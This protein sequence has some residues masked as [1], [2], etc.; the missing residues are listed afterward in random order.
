MKYT[1]QQ[2][3]NELNLSVSTVSRV[4]AGKQN[5][6]GQ[7]KEQ[8]LNY[9]REHE[10]S[11]PP[12]AGSCDGSGQIVAVIIP[13]LTED[14]FA[15]VIRGIEEILWQEKSSMM[16]CET[17]EDSTKEEQYIEVLRRKKIT[18]I[19]LATVSKDQERIRSYLRDDANIVF[20]DNLPNLTT[21]YNSV[22]TDNVRAS[23]MAV[24]HLV[25]QGHEKIGIIAGKQQETTGFER[26]VGYRRALD[27]RGI[28]QDESLVAIGNFKEESGYQCM[29]E[30]LDKNPG[31][32]A[33]Y[34]SSSKMTYGA[35]KAIFSR[36]LS[37]PQDIALVGF[38]VHDP[39]GLV[40][41]GITTILQNEANIGKL[42]VELLHKKE[43]QELAGSQALYQRILLEPRLVIRESC[44]YGNPKAQVSG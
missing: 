31:M 14:Y 12:A 2:I 24:D 21:N 28:G 33:V 19:I 13:D 1:L 37:I 17:M 39:T 15:H 26:L 4:L 8:V 27:M 41:P 42:C 44:G 29:L 22:I 7:T 10:Y 20:F 5:V 3:A 6:N 30:L 35:M 43:S 11:L 40:C 38:D 9:M 32:T 25:E 16:L 34:V 18:N 23:I 36:G